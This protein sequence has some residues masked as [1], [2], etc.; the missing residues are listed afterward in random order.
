MHVCVPDYFA[1]GVLGPDDQLAVTWVAA[2]LVDFER[3][4]FHPR[5]LF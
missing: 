1:R 2:Y 3:L 4:R 5:V